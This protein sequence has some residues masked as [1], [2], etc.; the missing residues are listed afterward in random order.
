MV[1]KEK[2]ETFDFTSLQD[3]FKQTK[4]LTN[5]MNRIWSAR[6]QQ[7]TKHRMIVQF[8]LYFLDFYC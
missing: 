3:M 5:N 6:E 4:N 2:S 7:Q 8:F 1:I